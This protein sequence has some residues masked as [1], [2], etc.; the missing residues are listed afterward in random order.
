MIH[1]VAR[2][3]HYRSSPT[4]VRCHWAFSDLIAAHVMIDITDEERARAA[5]EGKNG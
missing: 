4:A 3:E 2:D 1:R 5:K